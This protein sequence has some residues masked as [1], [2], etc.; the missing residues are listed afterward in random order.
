[1][2]L[3]KEIRELIIKKNQEYQ[4]LVQEHA[5]DP[6]R[7]PTERAQMTKGAVAAK[8]IKEVN[9]NS[10]FKSDLNKLIL[11]YKV[12]RHLNIYCYV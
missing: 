11:S 6:I 2:D 4:E 9:E 1:M 12:K 7:L 10:L 3:E 5:K 8:C